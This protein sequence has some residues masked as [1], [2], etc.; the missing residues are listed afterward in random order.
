VDEAD[1][2]RRTVVHHAAAGEAQSGHPDS[3]DGQ[4]DRRPGAA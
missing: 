1:Q 2:P 4:E 3:E